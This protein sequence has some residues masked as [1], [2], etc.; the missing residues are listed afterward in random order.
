[1]H[2]RH[3]YDARARIGKRAL[4]RA[5]SYRYTR[6]IERDGVFTLAGFAVA[7]ASIAVAGGVIFA[8]FKAAVFLLARLIT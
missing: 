3:R 4:N 1:M 6:L 8:F 2:A 7:I 5:R